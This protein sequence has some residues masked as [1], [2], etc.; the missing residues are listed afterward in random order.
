MLDCGAE[1]VPKSLSVAG[2]PRT[3]LWLPVVGALVETAQ[4]FVLL[5][6]GFSRAFLADSEAQVRV[7]RG[8]PPPRPP[9]ED[10][11]AALGLS[12]ADVALGAVSHLHC[13]HSGALR[14]LAAAGK[15]IAIHADEL[16][17]AQSRATLDDGYYAP[18]FEGLDS[19]WRVLD[20][21]AE[22]A[23][24]VVALATPGHTPGHLSFRVDLRETGTWLLAFDAA[25]LGE[26]LAD[27]TPPGWTALPEDAER[28]AASLARLCSEA[29]R[30]EAR[31]VPGHDA[32]FWRAVRHPPGGHR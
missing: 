26:N 16:A 19:A 2:A 21:D 13:D 27:R 28:A 1:C 8:G 25:D 23:D 4:G 17:F 15:R 24:G 10:P 12:R 30:L 11:V 14:P 32:A 18:D 9:E 6:G 20:G 29:E 22:L 3:R 5:D 31:L 7:Y